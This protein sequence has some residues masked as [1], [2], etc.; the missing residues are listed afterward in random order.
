MTFDFSDVDENLESEW[1]EL[2]SN[3][4][5]LVKRAF[6]MYKLAQADNPELSSK[7]WNAMVPEMLAERYDAELT[8][9]RHHL[10]RAM[11]EKRRDGKSKRRQR[12]QSGGDSKRRDK[13]DAATQNWLCMIGELLDNVFDNYQTSLESGYDENLE[14]EI[15]FTKVPISKDDSSDCPI[16]SRIEIQENSGG[17]PEEKAE[18]LWLTKASSKT[19]ERHSVGMHNRGLKLALPHFGYWQVIETWH[20]GD[21]PSSTGEVGSSWAQGSE[22]E[23]SGDDPQSDDAADYWHDDN[24]Y[25]G[26]PENNYLGIPGVKSGD[27]LLEMPGRT[28]ITIRRLTESGLR[29]LDDSVE[30]HKLIEFI[31]RIWSR[32]VGKLLD[33]HQKTT[34]IR[35]FHATEAYKPIVVTND[36]DLLQDTESDHVW[37]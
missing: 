32:L 27:W 10:G 12:A 30:F 13:G 17:I 3:P 7:E 11:V 34:T 25:R 31:S 18:N 35:M 2:I 36:E 14:I 24:E 19:S 23:P 29:V 8:E 4:K 1:D 15:S 6:D 28:R 37:N 22:D 5:K 33:E 20:I 26:T 16:H 21:E 9:V